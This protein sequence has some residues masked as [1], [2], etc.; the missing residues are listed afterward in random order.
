MTKRKKQ[1]IIILL[2]LLLVYTPI[3][4][5]S[6]NLIREYNEFE[7]YNV[8]GYSTGNIIVDMADSISGGE[9]S[10]MT[11]EELEIYGSPWRRFTELLSAGYDESITQAVN[12]FTVTDVKDESPLDSYYIYIDEYSYNHLVSDLPQSGFQEVKGYLKYNDGAMQKVDLRFRGDNTWHWYFTQKSWR[13]KTEKDALINGA[14]KINLINPLERSATVD[15][16][17]FLIADKMGV[18]A[19]DARPVRVF[20]NNN[21]MGVAIETAQ[22]DEYFL[23]NN[24]LLPSELYSGDHVWIDENNRNLGYYGT[25]LFETADTSG[26]V[27]MAENNNIAAD[28]FTLLYN[29]IEFVEGNQQQIFSYEIENYVDIEKYLNWRACM[30]IIGSIH[31]NNNHNQKLYFDPSS[32]KMQP[33]L[34]DTDGLAYI[35]Y[36]RPLYWPINDMDAVIMKN[37]EYADEMLKIV[38]E[39]I[40]ES[41]T[42]EDAQQMTD[43]AYESMRQ[44]IY[45]D[46]YKDNVVKF[47]FNRSY[48]NKEFDLSYYDTKE[49][50]TNRYG[51]INQALE[52]TKLE[53]M[54]EQDGSVQIMKVL[55]DGLTGA[56]IASIDFEDIAGGTKIYRDTNL[57]GKLDEDDAEVA[58]A[59]DGNSAVLM[60]E[61][62]YP[63]LLDK[64]Y[65]DFGDNF[66]PWANACQSPE[67]TYIVTGGGNITGITAENTVTEQQMEC[68]AAEELSFADKQDYTTHPWSIQ[69]DTQR[70][71]VV[72]EAGEYII[73][74]DLII[75]RY[76]TLQI[77]AGAK[78][79]MKP[80]VSIY[81]FGQLHIEG[82]EENPVVIKAFDE[83]K[84]W[85]VL[86]LQGHYNPGAV[87]T[88]DYALIEG[89]GVPQTYD[90]AMYT[91]MV[92]A[93]NTNLVLTNSEVSYNKVGDDGI[94]IKQGSL[95][96][97][98]C[99][100]RGANSDAIDFDYSTGSISGCYFTES[101]NDAID[102]MTSPVRIENCYIEKSGDKGISIGERSAPVIINNIIYGCNIGVEIKDV[103][104]PQIDSCVIAHCGIGINAYLKNDKYEGGGLGTIENTMIIG[105]GTSA[106]ADKKS[107]VKFI[108]CLTDKEIAQS[109]N[110]D[111]SGDVMT[112]ND[113]IDY[114]KVQQ[115]E[116][117]GI[118]L[119]EAI[120]TWW[121]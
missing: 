98:M 3:F 74:E 77:N 101:G 92:S 105:C 29:L 47:T 121:E 91:G 65:T 73:E 21:Y 60:D 43:Y 28:D 119:A 39:T 10:E 62:I 41:V 50:I 61:K 56:E 93:Y 111:I 88:I 59:L 52:Y 109:E 90:N 38:Y 75:N 13:I 71:D 100:F 76:S 36:L 97:E 95:K 80:N 15:Y 79:L 72:F 85:G 24:N 99:V 69:K 27:K 8:F 9:D 78:L 67:Y 5:I 18:L 107:Y 30:N 116:Y 64:K 19:T 17:S 4:F 58:F 37:P 117:A 6:V 26:W 11:E 40:N 96:A 25:Q 46:L 86:A 44:D 54:I 32:G 114:S 23:R 106:S 108:N 115:G 7:T 104:D 20:V 45:A 48:T 120:D 53:Y 82:T 34:W 83:K 51:Y 110:I 87:H 68:I 84:P 103:S 81:V 57:N 66:A 14:R 31:A 94:N 118:G 55:V 2:I 33:I 12:L 35:P 70:S 16:L 112:T 63:V 42:E 102:L 49:W 113:T 22:T 1:S 89:G